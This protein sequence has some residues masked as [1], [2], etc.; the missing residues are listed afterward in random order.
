[1]K[2]HNTTKQPS[3]QKAISNKTSSREQK[4]NAMK[5]HEAPISQQKSATAETLAGAAT[6][7]PVSDL[8]VNVSAASALVANG[9]KE[10]QK[11]EI[12]DGE[13][14]K[15]GTEAGTNVDASK[16]E[17]SVGSVCSSGAEMTPEEASEAQDRVGFFVRTPPTPHNKHKQHF[18]FRSVGNYEY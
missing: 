7:K 17:G 18:L 1:M 12:N 15:G 8:K 4:S 3:K 11:T 5:D 9:G 16:T 10:L 2:K 14:G 6:G 13:H